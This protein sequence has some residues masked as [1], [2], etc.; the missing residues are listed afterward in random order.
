MKR[1]FKLFFSKHEECQWLNKMGVKGYR[2]EKIS[3]SY[4]YFE[5]EKNTIFSYSIEYLDCPQKSEQAIEHF[6]IRKNKGENH[7]FR[8]GKWDYFRSNGK[9]INL[10][11]EGKNKI[12]NLYF[13]RTLY[14]FF[15]S[16]VSTLLCGYQM[17]ALTY[18]E[19]FEH[20]GDGKF[21][22]L[23]PK[24]K[25][26]FDKL[27]L[28]WNEILDFFN[29]TY[30]KIFTKIFGENPVALVMAFLLPITIVLIT[31]FAMNLDEYIFWRFTNNGKFS[32]KS[33]KQTKEKR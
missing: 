9:K 26:F 29:N 32:Y 2:L 6:E 23:V 8:K 28:F 5:H 22:M 20:R 17:F 15:F 24:G 25:P 19:I 12:S 14:L 10:T 21:D 30:F 11:A 3:R 27:K 1:C 18:L 7:L 16:L 13:W 4:Y 31:L 33:K